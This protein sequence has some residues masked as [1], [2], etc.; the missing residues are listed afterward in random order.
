MQ[1]SKE[2]LEHAF[3]QSAHFRYHTGVWAVSL[4]RLNTKFCSSFKGRPIM[5]LHCVF[6][7]NSVPLV[8]DSATVASIATRQGNNAGPSAR[9][10]PCHW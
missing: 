7:D 6:K 1:C 2:L 9:H 4:L 8:L 3:W 10:W 5:Q